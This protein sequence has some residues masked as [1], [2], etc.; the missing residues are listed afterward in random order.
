MLHRI[1]T[2][3]IA[4][5]ALLTVQAQKVCTIKGE[6]KN[7][8]KSVKM[9]YLTRID[10]YDRLINIDSAKVKKGKYS[11]KHKIENEE[12]AMLYLITGLENGNIEL[13][14]E[15]GNIKVCTDD[16]S[17]PQESSVNGT[18]TN[19]LYSEYRSIYNNAIKELQ[20]TLSTIACSKGNEWMESKEGKETIQQIEALSTMKCSYERIE[21]LL[22]NNQSPLSPL[23]FKRDIIAMIGNVYAQQVVDAIDPS[24]HK[25]PYYRA[26]SNSVLSRDIKEGELLPDIT[27]P[28]RDGTITHLS[29]YRG[30]YIVLYFWAGWCKPCQGEMPNLRRLYDETREYDDK[31]NIVCFAVE[32]SLE[33][34]CNSISTQ[35]L[36]REGIVHGCDFFGKKSPMMKMLNIGG[37][38]YA[39][40]LNPEGKLITQNIR[41]E[42]LIERVK[43]IL[44][45]N[46]YNSEVK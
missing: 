39:F 4:A 8:D 6:I 9:L 43:D 11:F 45:N 32:N 41:G 44:K 2:F 1:I 28:L 37:I 14:V 17:Q 31:F 35:D 3:A 5:T 16:A 33:E 34:W 42:R 27:I 30:K 12:P 24:L 23:M 22:A 18:A 38:P 29:D 36:D 21:F 7:P 20:D 26:L 13:F 19:E 40:I 15:P 25:H 10:E 46:L